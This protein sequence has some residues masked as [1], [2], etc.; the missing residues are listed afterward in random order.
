MTNH[1]SAP[2]VTHMQV[3]FLTCI[4]SQ[5]MTS[6]SF[7]CSE[8]R[9]MIQLVAVVAENVK[10]GIHAVNI[11]LTACLCMMSLLDMV[12]CHGSTTLSIVYRPIHSL[13]TLTQTQ[14]IQIHELVII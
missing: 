6:C 14:L 8:P 7:Q 3:N 13:C 9:C 12:R 10:H 5:E 2:H 4:V 11:L 1:H